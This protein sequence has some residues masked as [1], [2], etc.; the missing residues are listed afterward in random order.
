MNYSKPTV[1]DFL[2]GVS[3]FNQ[4]PSA[5]LAKLSGQLQPL[6]EE[7]GLLPSQP[8]FLFQSFN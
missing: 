7:G 8:S 1:Q 5:S 4:L 3:P 2:A 6:L